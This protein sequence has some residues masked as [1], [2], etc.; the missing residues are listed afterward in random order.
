MLEIKINFTKLTNLSSSKN[1]TPVLILSE[2]EVKKSKFKS[3]IDDQAPGFTG[4]NGQINII[5]FDEK[6]ILLL[7][8]VGEEKKV[9]D[10]ILQ[11]IGARIVSFANSSKMENL[12]LFFGVEIDN[13]KLK[14]TTKN[15][16]Y[17]LSNLAFGACLFS[18]R[19]NKYFNAKKAEKEF[20]VK[21]I[22]IA[23]KDA[24]KSKEQFKQF[25]ILTDNILL[26]RN[27]VSEPAN[28]LY[29]ESYAKI[30]LGFKKDGLEV[31]VLDQKT[32]QKLG[33]NSLLGVGQGSVKE[34]KLVVLK[35]LG[36]K[37]KKAQPLAFVGKG[38]TF[39]TGGISIK[40]SQNMEDMKLDMAGSAVVVSLLRLLAQR[41]AKVNVIGV[42]GLVENIPSGSAQ[43]PGDVIKSMSGQT[44]E[45]INTDAEGRLVLADALHYANT[46]FK[47]KLIVDLATLT[48]AIIVC[49]ADVYSGLF[50]NDDDLSQK[51]IAA[52]EKTG[53]LT[54]RM[55]LLEEYDEMINSDI[56]DMKNLG[57]GRG[58]GSITA[59]QF[60]KRFIGDTKWAHLDIAGVAWKN[61]GD[62]LA[63]K[64]AT[65]YGVRLLNQFIIDNYEK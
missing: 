49:L 20:K 21:S 3:I 18:Y 53:E 32:M 27:L 17:N 40:P 45:V 37:D 16:P 36:A 14:Y 24:N 19:F 39:D 60:L 61:N 47:P 52:G 7:V 4:K 44:I 51:L 30:C 38:V 26:T 48:G 2:E 63:V 22:T 46:K 62:P 65:G 28:V 64:G 12:A 42:I 23:S 8:G 1:F 5:G 15:N 31:E 13:G 50:S 10:L 11:K 57:S 43:R 41:K 58:A 34:S 59:A 54:W 33:M 55:P 56:A 9:D 25:E 35:W 29:P 6:N